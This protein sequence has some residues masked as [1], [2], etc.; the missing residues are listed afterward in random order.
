MEGDRAS[1]GP[2]WAS[3]AHLVSWL[4]LPLAGA[5]WAIAAFGDWSHETEGI[6]WVL[7]TLLPVFLAVGAG[8]G[9][10]ALWK[11]YRPAWLPLLIHLAL[12]LIVFSVVYHR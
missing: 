1:R 10:A 3:P 12:G 9:F 8:T 5:V 2:R 6:F 4:C 11:G 7:L